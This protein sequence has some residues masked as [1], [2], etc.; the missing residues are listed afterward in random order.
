MQNIKSCIG[1]VTKD[2]KD[3]MEAKLNIEVFERY[4]K[5]INGKLSLLMKNF[6]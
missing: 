5:Y 2:L 6:F 4:Q 3:F 1:Q